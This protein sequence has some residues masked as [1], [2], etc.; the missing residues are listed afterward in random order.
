[1]VLSKREKYI[2]LG[3]GAALALLVLDQ[4]LL[5][6]YFKRLDEIDTQ[7]RQV[8]QAQQQANDTFQRQRKLT[9]VWSE[10]QR[11]GLRSNPSEAESQ[12]RRAVLS[13]AQTAGVFVTALNPDRTTT[14]GKFQIISLNATGNG[15]MPQIAR[16]LWT[17]ETATIPVRVNEITI[18]P[19]REGTDELQVKFVVS[20]LCLPPDTAAPQQKAA[21]SAADYRGWE[22]S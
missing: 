14:V 16:L 22:G 7:R 2:G 5:S 20:T 1:V 17:L 9:P 4:F 19:R 8:M 6:P 11:S 12:A 21:V 10:I 13:W 18:T 15:S 3:V